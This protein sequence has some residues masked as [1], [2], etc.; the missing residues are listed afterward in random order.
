MQLGAKKLNKPF[1]DDDEDELLTK[2][3]EDATKDEKVPNRKNH[4]DEEY[5]KKLQEALN[6]E[7][8]S[9]TTSPSFYRPNNS[10]SSGTF[11]ALP[12]SGDNLSIPVELD[13]P[14]TVVPTAEYGMFVQLKK[15]SNAVKVMCLVDF[16]FGIYTLI[17]NQWWLSF[18]IV[19]API[20]AYGAHIF[21][22]KLLAAYLLYL[23]CI[24]ILESI[25]AFVKLN[26]LVTTL[27]LLIVGIQICIMYYTY[28]FFKAIPS[29]GVTRFLQAEVN[30][31]LQTL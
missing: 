12:K 31:P 8:A 14:N 4:D 3:I 16:L 17:F 28:T 6:A 13:P 27:S 7:T 20:G 5:A 18:G 2:E 22:R 10:S 19:F 30:L 24:I 9:T 15:K 25:F 26:G 1:E 11:A 23:C 21:N 29:D